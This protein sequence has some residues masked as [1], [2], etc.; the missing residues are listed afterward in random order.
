MRNTHSEPR[1]I[2]VAV[3]AVSTTNG[4]SSLNAAFERI[5]QMESQ[6]QDDSAYDLAFNTGLTNIATADGTAVK[7]A[8]VGRDN[9]NVHVFGLGKFGSSYV[10]KFIETAANHA[11]IATTMTATVDIS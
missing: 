3:R 4:V 2:D 6:I 10:L 5:A 9:L 8:V 1:A 11:A 7:I